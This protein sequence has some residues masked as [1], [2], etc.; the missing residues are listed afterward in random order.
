MRGVND[1]FGWQDKTPIRSQIII[2][3][4]AGHGSSAPGIRKFTTVLQAQG[5]AITW[6]PDAVLG[7]TFTISQRGTYCIFYQDQYASGTTEIGITLNEGVAT[8]STPIT[9]VTFPQ[10][11]RAA[12]QSAVGA[13]SFVSWAYEL[14]P[15]DVLRMHTDG[16]PTETS[17]TKVRVTIVK[18]DNSGSV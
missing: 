17:T 9:S 10:G 3:G 12:S 5:G 2:G 8:F 15:G 1:L 18:I 14:N 7:D 11:Q 16:S 4:G 6:M 13:F